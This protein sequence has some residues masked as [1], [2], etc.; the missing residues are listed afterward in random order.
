MKLA[1]C[2]SLP[3]IMAI[4]N[5]LRGSTFPKPFDIISCTFIFTMIMGSIYGYVF[6]TMT[7][8][9]LLKFIPVPVFYTDLILI[10]LLFWFGASW[11]WGKWVG[12]I[13]ENKPQYDVKPNVQWI[14]DI[15]NYFI[16]EKDNFLGYSKLALFIRGLLWWAP[17]YI[18]FVPINPCLIITNIIGVSFWFIVSFTI[19]CI[20]HNNI[21]DFPTIPILVPR[22]PD[23]P[24]GWGNYA[25]AWGELIYGFIQGF[26]LVLFLI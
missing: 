18:L 17:V 25:W 5:R 7:N 21:G 19:T 16:P 24:E 11:G 4:L 20:W 8:I 3:F 13:I 12:S 6:A 23:Y 1:I 10:V 22:Q 9:H 2:L 14:H 26:F 15:A